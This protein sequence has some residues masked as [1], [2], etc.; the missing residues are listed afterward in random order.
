MMKRFARIDPLAAAPCQ[1]LS[2]T[3]SEE[4]SPAPELL[5]L[6]DAPL[7]SEGSW[8]WAPEG[9]FVEPP[10]SPLHAWMAGGWVL[11][12]VQSQQAQAVAE[13]EWRDQAMTP[14]FS[15][16]DRHRDEQDMGNATTL[17]AEQFTELLVYIQ[18]LRDW[19]QSPDF[20]SSA[21]R[22]LAPPWF[23]EQY[24]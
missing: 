1:V 19:P 8:Y 14:A 6:A 13:R 17:T 22:P 24:Q 16:R 10:P 2:I 23:A 12:E 7:V 4:F 3:E 21:Q 18:A 9:R 11:D 5:D 15:M 20:P